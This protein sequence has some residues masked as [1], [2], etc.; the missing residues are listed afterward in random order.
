MKEEATVNQR[1]AASAKRRL[2]WTAPVAFVVTVVL[3]FALVVAVHA[4][5]TAKGPVTIQSGAFVKPASAK[6]P[7]FSLPVL[8]PPAG[9]PTSQAPVTLRSLVGHPVVLN[10]W[11]SSCTVCKAETPA[12]EAVAAREHAVSF[13]GVDTIDQKAAALDFLRKFHVSYLQLSDPNEVVGS[14][15]AIPGLPVS[16]FISARGKVVGEYLGA[17]TVKTLTHYLASLF[18]LH[19]PLSATSAR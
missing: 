3:V 19:V 7:N 14:G 16:V 15:Y 12:I 18:G 6:S 4:T 17:L 11:S 1:S 2:R 9:Q 5:E 8:Q 10:M 13:V